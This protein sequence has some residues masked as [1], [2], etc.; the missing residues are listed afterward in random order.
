SATARLRPKPPTPTEPDT[1]PPLRGG[2][3]PKGRWGRSLRESSNGAFP[4]GCAHPPLRGYFPRFAGEGVSGFVEGLALWLSGGPPG[5]PAR[6]R[7]TSA[8]ATA[9]SAGS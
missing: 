3:C 8:A 2:R 5:R 9:G 7:A 4:R 6:R 1:L